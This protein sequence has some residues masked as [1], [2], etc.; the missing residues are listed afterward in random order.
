MK[1]KRIKFLLGLVIAIT[2]VIYFGC[3]KDT[4]ETYFR[5]GP[6]IYLNNDTIKANV[7]L[8]ILPKV[9]GI[10]TSN[11]GLKSVRIYTI[12]SSDTVLRNEITSFDNPNK[13]MY[14]DSSITYLSNITAIWIE[15]VDVRDQKVGKRQP[16]KIT[17]AA[18]PVISFDS[19]S[20]NV[21]R[22][23]NEHPNINVSVASVYLL[24][25]YKVTLLDSIAGNTVL[26]ETTFSDST[27]SIA[28]SYTITYT[29]NIKGV[30]VE[31]EDV[32][33]QAVTK[34]LKLAIDYLP[35]GRP[36]IKFDDSVMIALPLNALP[37]Y[38]YA[39]VKTETNLVYVRSYITDNGIERQVGEETSFSNPYEYRV[40]IKPD[41]TVLTS[42]LRIEAKDAYGT[43]NSQTIPVII[44]PADLNYWPNIHLWTLGERSAKRFAFSSS[45]S[46]SYMLYS[47]TVP[48]AN[49]MAVENCSRI[50]W[51]MGGSLNS[52]TKI[53]EWRFYSPAYDDANTVADYNNCIDAVNK[54][55]SWS[56]AGWMYKNVYKSSN[57][58]STP[59]AASGCNDRLWPVRNATMF[60]VLNPS[61][62][63][64]DVVDFTTLTRDKL[65]LVPDS[66]VSGSGKTVAAMKT[67]VAVPS[68]VMTTTLVL[69]KT[70]AGKRG[71]IRLKSQS[72]VD[73]SKNGRLVFDVKVE[74]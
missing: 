10:I 9:E 29:H 14:I 30:L 65:N 33:H 11:L 32:K 4:F 13:Y 17:I 22:G 18:A 3:K 64:N 12:E 25:S 39:T 41:F 55:T 68:N 72:N 38:F 54:G 27:T 24:K 49:G 40:A 1:N 53:W 16:V 62:Y 45:D 28:K 21:N 34:T 70:A 43:V 47:E 37:D 15:A 35:F 20:I 26:E 61:K 59:S 58:G 51:F 19:D 48:E 46:T 8:G 23:K 63:E 73:N 66:V 69:F 2:A 44:L 56:V 74:K 7:T 6:V 50:D 67:L 5:P 57:G 71:L 42:Q 31:V 52:T 60:R 36:Q